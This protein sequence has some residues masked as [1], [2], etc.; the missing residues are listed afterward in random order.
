MKG[1]E[2][3]YKDYKNIEIW[4]DHVKQKAPVFEEYSRQD[5]A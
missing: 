1:H 4:R 2:R 5:A 3:V